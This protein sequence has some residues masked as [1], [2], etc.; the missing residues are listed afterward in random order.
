MTVLPLPVQAALAAVVLASAASDIR[1]RNIPNW[2]TLGAVAAGLVLN[3]ALSGWPGL[4]LSAIGLAAAALIFLPLFIMRWLGGGDVKLMAAIGAF[5]GVENLIV[6]FILDAIFGGAVALAVILFKGRLA[7]TLR[8]IPR[9]FAKERDGELEAGHEKS[10][11][12]PRAV[13]IAL[14]TLLVL[15]ASNQPPGR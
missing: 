8:N 11:G 9:M 15:W 7:K 14:A 6:V 1:S 4:K 2:L 10:L 12:M 13:T 5:S 3:T